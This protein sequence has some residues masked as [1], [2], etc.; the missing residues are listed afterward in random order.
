M[1]DLL[2][3]AVAMATFKALHKQNRTLKDS[4]RL[5][6]ARRARPGIS[7]KDTCTAMLFAGIGF[8][9]CVL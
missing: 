2:C 7:R 1:Q 3:T 4:T 8:I 6:G 9:M 5:W